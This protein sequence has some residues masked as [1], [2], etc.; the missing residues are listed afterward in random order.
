MNTEQR[1]REMV[2]RVVYRAV[3]KAPVPKS[4]RERGGA[5][6]TESDLRDV[7]R[8]GQF[9]VS[10][11]AL[12]TP[13]AR[14]AAM[15]RQVTLVERGGT[16]PE[17]SHQ[18]QSRRGEPGR[19]TVA[20]GADHGGYAFKEMLKGHLSDQG[21]EVVDCGTEGTE[22]VDYPD[23][24]LAVA[25]LVAEGRAWRRQ[26]GAR[27]SRSLVLRRGDGG[28]QP[29]PQR[30]ERPDAR[31]GDDR[32]GRWTA[33]RHSVAGDPGRRRPAYPAGQQDHGHR[34]PIPE[35]RMITRVPDGRSS[36]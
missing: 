30:R 26:Q 2:R 15:E 13:L 28:Q 3:G 34:T 19:K 25:Q 29:G 14:Q 4:G 23:F 27:R 32:P 33:D 8:G 10:R 11:G 35:E 9:E 1:I 21:Y 22:S 12:V 31:R 24:A 20:I 5:L 6:V 17:A 18:R 7:V 16:G 36:R